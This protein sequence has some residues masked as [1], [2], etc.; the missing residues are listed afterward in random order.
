M[1][2]GYARVSTKGQMKL[3]NSLEQQIK[4]LQENGVIKENIFFDAYTGTKMDRPEF[5]KLLSKL[6]K[7]DTLIVTKLDRF[8]RSTSEGIR[9]VKD[10]FE[11]GVT[12]H[13]L[14]IGIIENTATG[15]LLFNVFMAFAEFERNMI[16]ERTQE[17]KAIARERGDFKDGRPKK[18]KKAQLQH[19]MELLDQYTYKKV[20]EITGISKSTLIRARKAQKESAIA[21]H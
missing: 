7:G 9:I 2:Y 19:A 13:I 5:K 14:N 4:I 1:K 20:E 15:N 10:L 8:A 12:V 17:G 21:S 18:F 6:K 16:I 11:K 3:G